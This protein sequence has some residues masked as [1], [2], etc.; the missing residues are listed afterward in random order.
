M[1]NTTKTL[2]LLTGMTLL[3][4]ALGGYFGGRSGM[5]LAL[6]FAGVMN[7]GSWW[8]SDKIVLKLNRA[9]P[10]TP[11]EAPDLHASIERLARKAGMPKPKVCLVEDP[12][13]NAFAT[14]RNPAHGVVDEYGRCHDLR[15]LYIADTGVFPQ[16]PSINPMWT[17]MALAHRTA[18][19]LRAEL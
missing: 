10:V 13:P 9:R 19:H 11:E 15:N 18:A 1:W 2:F 14:G 3:L 6:V 12:A 16:C 17:V 8:F 4:V 5:I 7:V